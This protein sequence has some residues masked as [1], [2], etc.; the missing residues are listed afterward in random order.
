VAELRPAGNVL[1]IACGTGAW[2]GALAAVASSVTAID[3]APEAIGIARSQITAANV[4]FEVADAFSWTAPDRFDTVFLAFWLSHVP[5]SRFGPFWRQLCELVAKHGRV[6][7][8]DEHPAVRDKEDYAPGSDEIIRRRLAGGSEYRLVKVFVHPASCR[9]GYASSA[10]TATSAGTAMTGSS[11]KPA[12]SGRSRGA[13]R[14]AGFTG[15]S[16][17][18]PPTRSGLPCESQL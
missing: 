14:R 13:L 2:I 12:P 15:Q 16:D 7:L 10:G 5:A 18:G 8:V 4:R 17:T 6:L 1:E 3:A 11:A 9:P